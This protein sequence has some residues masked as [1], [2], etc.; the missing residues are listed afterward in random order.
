MADRNGLT[1]C[2]WVVTLGCTALALASLGIVGEKGREPARRAVCLANLR[3]LT[4]AWTLYA[5]DNNGRIVNAAGGFHFT[6]AGTTS[7]G[8]DPAIVERAWVGKSWRD[9]YRN[10]VSPDEA[11]FTELQK[12][13]AIREGALWPYVGD[14]R[15]YRCPVGRAYEFVNYSIVD[16]MNGYNASNG[17]TGVSTGDNHVTAV[18]TRLGDTVLWIKR[19]AEIISP[20]ASQRIVFVDE[21]AMTPDSY[22]VR[23][24]PGPWW[25]NP[26]VRHNDGT[27]VSWADGHTSYLQWK[28]PET[29]EYGRQYMDYYGGGVFTPKTPEGIKDLEDFRRAVWGWLGSE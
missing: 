9:N 13:Q 7:D 17:R 22:A 28:A 5:D 16:A 23:Y 6:R 24:V 2:D 14:R 26:P 18:G 1:R 8:S 12:Q 25:D 20:A 3:Q 15:F 21:G 4:S 19:R 27:T 29:I 11:G 10:P